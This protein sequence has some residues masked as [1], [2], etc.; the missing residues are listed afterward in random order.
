MDPA[1]R[2]RWQLA[3]SVMDT[4]GCWG[5]TALHVLGQCAEQFPED[6][7]PTKLHWWRSCLSAALERE[8]SRLL[9][10]RT[11]EAWG[12]SYHPHPTP[13]SFWGEGDI[14]YFIH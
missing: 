3:P 10:L 14:P 11:E 8:N 2:G 4:F 7:R 5:N 1:V 6:A 9:R 13:V 12:A